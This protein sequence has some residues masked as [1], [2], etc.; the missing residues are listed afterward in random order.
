MEPN[1]IHTKSSNWFFNRKHFPA[2]DGAVMCLLAL[3]PVS[4]THL[5]VYKR[6]IQD[7]E[8]G[9]E[10]KLSVLDTVTMTEREHNEVSSSTI[11]NCFWQGGTEFLIEI[12]RAVAVNDEELLKRIR[13][14]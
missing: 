10:T 2:S 14:K 7:I 9:K 12:Q 6:Q 11:P 4:Y 3:L 5:D 13:K 8:E 1:S